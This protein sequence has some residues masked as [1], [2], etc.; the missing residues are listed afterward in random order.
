MLFFLVVILIILAVLGAAYYQHRKKNKDNSDLNVPGEDEWLGNSSVFRT[1]IKM[2]S[3]NDALEESKQFIYNI[4]KTVMQRFAPDQKNIVLDLGRK[5]LNAGVKY[6][7][8]VDVFAL[9]LGKKM[10]RIKQPQ[11]NKSKGPSVG[12]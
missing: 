4:A 3:Y 9:S 12:R 7:H 2:L 1:D 11:E 5:L 8:V 10:S 6:V